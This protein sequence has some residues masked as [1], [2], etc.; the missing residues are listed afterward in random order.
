[1]MLRQLLSVIELLR[2]GTSQGTRLKIGQLEFLTGIH[3]DFLT[4]Y[5]EKFSNSK[6][7]NIPIGSFNILNLHLKTLIRLNFQLKV[8]LSAL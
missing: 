7:Y 2:K 3:G 1:M 4:G 5:H 8:L 6:F